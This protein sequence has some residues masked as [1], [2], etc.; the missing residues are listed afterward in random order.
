MENETITVYK[1]HKFNM[2]LIELLTSNSFHCSTREQL[3]DPHDLKFLAS[4][5]LIEDIFLGNINIG[6]SSDELFK[7]F[8]LHLHNNELIC[9]WEKPSD[10]IN[11]VCSSFFATDLFSDIIINHFNYRIISFC[12]E[13]SSKQNLM[14]GHYAQHNGVRLK[15]EF[16][17]DQIHS[18]ANYYGLRQVNYDNYI[19]LVENENNIFDSLLSKHINWNY[20]NEYRIIT[21]G[22]TK[23]KFSKSILKEISFGDQVSQINKE[24]LIRICRNFNYDCKFKFLSIDPSYN[25]IIVRNEYIDS[26]MKLP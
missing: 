11:A 19:K 9:E 26:I 2:H 5:K 14:W 25:Y 13:D 1:Y 23:Y 20:E 15:F 10:R 3:N 7:L 8:C 16:P 24:L 18:T 6:K 21:K 17:K 22:L 4:N 12:G